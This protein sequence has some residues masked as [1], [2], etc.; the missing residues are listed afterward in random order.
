MPDQEVENNRDLVNIKNWLCKQP[1]L[2]HDVDELLLRRFLASCGHSLER[3]K[4]TID[5]FFTIRSNAPEVFFK[6]DPWSPEIQRVFQ[7]TDLIPLPKKTKEN[8]KVF[9]YRLNNPDL[10]MFN[11]IDAVKTFFMLADTRLTEEEDVPAGEI[12]IFDSSNVSL[13]FISKINLSVLR[14]YMLYTQEAIPIRLKQVHVINAPA[15]I[16]KIHAI[17][18]PFIKAEVAKLIKFHEPNTDTLYKDIP[19]DL[20]PEEYGGK[21]GSIDQLKKYWI[22]RIEAKR[23]WF[24]THDQ[25]W[26]VDESLRP[27][28]CQD[29][30]ADKVRDC[31]GSF[32]SLALD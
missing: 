30:R 28:S 8:Y 9:I 32:R 17:C 11:F 20:L 4:R 19:Q 25:R 23:E 5:L 2:P 1:H 15:Y 13:K 21:A 16:S 3:T 18:K 7:I 31:P 14:K 12:P 29:E 22:K 27:S 26:V 10:D 6:R 24:L